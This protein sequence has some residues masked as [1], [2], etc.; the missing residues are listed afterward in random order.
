MFVEVRRGPFQQQQKSCLFRIN[1]KTQTLCIN[2]KK[3]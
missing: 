2:L 1:H 3:S